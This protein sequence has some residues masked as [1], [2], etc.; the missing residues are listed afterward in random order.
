MWIRNVHYGR[1]KEDCTAADIGPSRTSSFRYGE[2]LM[3]LICSWGPDGHA[4]G[5]CASAARTD[6]EPESAT[7]N[8][9][10]ALKAK[11]LTSTSSSTRR[12]PRS[13]RARSLRALIPLN[14][15]ECPFEAD[16]FNRAAARAL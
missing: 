1:R 16:T 8:A 14:A 2:K 6:A 9:T 3:R 5:G 13:A 11:R 4:R 10:S 12:S 7:E 15:Q